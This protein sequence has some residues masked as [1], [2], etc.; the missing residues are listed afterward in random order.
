MKYKLSDQEIY[1]NIDE[2][3]IRRAI[4]NLINNAISHNELGT[5]IYVSLSISDKIR[6]VI[7]DTGNEISANLK[8][9][10]LILLY[11]ERNLGAILVTMVWACLSYIE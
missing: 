3:E 5:K 7:A 10:I 2:T 4:G 6:L 8:K 1:A 11:V 9:D